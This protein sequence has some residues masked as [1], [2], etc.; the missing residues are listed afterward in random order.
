MVHQQIYPPL[1]GFPASIELFILIEAKG[2][3][4]VQEATVIE[5]QISLSIAVESVHGI[6]GVQGVDR[7]MNIVRVETLDKPLPSLTT[8]SWNRVLRPG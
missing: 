2:P 6:T 4:E 5:R 7:R 1:H 8:R 3:L